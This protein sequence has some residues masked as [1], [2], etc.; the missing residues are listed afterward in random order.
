[1][2]SEKI[3]R[4]QA[5]LISSTN[6]GLSVPLLLSNPSLPRYLV[7]LNGYFDFALLHFTPRQQDRL[8]RRPQ[9]SLDH[10][11][12]KVLDPALQVP[13]PADSITMLS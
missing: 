9:S 1:M 13:H 8:I 11:A 12:H 3:C 2:A 10:G 7:V 4:F 6:F 5:W